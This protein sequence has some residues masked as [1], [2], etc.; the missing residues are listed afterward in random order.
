MRCRFTTFTGIMLL[1][2]SN[3]MAVCTPIRI[4]YPNQHRP[5]YWSGEGSRVAEPPGA[6]V[7]LVRQFTASAGCTSALKRFPVLRI[8]EALATGEIDF[9]PMGA[10]EQDTPNIAYPRDKNGAPDIERAVP[11]VI[12][13]FVRG[14]DAASGDLSP[15]GRFQGQ[16]L[17]TTHGATY[18]DRLRRAGFL[19]DSGAADVAS[20]FEKLRLHRIDGFA[21]SLISPN[22]M[23]AFVAAKYGA[24]F[25]RLGQPLFSDYIWLAANQHYYDQHASQTEAM[26]N[27]LGSEG[28]K[29]FTKLIKKYSTEH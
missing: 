3:A 9:A 5:P 8:K 6:S 22:D 21:I 1:L 15:A 19:V 12:V 16:R 20:N 4:G 26:W 27:W 10:T 23:D 11:I 17:G 28:K 18:S 2:C 14:G 7:E 25:V 13:V 24:Q 29:E